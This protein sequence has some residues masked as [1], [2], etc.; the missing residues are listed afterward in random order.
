M[1]A[2]KSSIDTKLIR[3][4]A[5]MLNETDLNEIEVKKGDLRL[6]LSRGGT[7]TAAPVMTHAQVAPAPMAAPVAEA[8][9]VE[10]PAAAATTDGSPAVFC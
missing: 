6:R 1:A 2:K 9:P 10:A 5:N 4:L 8:A 3:E 7:M